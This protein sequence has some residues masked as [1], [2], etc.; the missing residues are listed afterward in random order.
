MK[1]HVLVLLLGTLALGGCVSASKFKDQQ[2]RADVLEK[3]LSAAKTAAD[4]AA[5]KAAD[6]DAGLQIQLKAGADQLASLN[7]QLASVQKSNKDLQ[8]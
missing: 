8:E 4:A 3:D 5:K 6:T 2:K 7:T 1:R